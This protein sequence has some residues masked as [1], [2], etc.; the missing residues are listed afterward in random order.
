MAQRTAQ[1][2]C[3][4]SKRQGRSVLVAMHGP[5]AH[6]GG[7][8]CTCKTRKRGATAVHVLARH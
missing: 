3:A 4:F 1:H 6:S 8:W 7:A 2:H 5:L